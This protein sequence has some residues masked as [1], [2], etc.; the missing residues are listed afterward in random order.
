MYYLPK[1]VRAEDLALMRSID[2]LH[3]THPFMG[4][5]SCAANWPERAF[6]ST[7]ATLAR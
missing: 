2:E 5:S 1:P 4:A 3:L 7:G 6:M